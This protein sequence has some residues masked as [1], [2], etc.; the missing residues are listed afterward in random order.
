MNKISKDTISKETLRPNTSDYCH[1]YSKSI[2]RQ[3]YN[4]AVNYAYFFTV[5][6]DNVFFPLK[7]LWNI[8]WI[9]ILFNKHAKQIHIEFMLFI[10]YFRF[11]KKP[12]MHRIYDIYNKCL[13]RYSVKHCFRSIPLCTLKVR[14]ETPIVL[15]YIF[16][17]FSLLVSI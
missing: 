14:C 11:K 17:I 10:Y 2:S 9:V 3:L 6:A 13:L 16:I 15:Q 1:H 8:F 7:Y 5:N 12:D 4:V